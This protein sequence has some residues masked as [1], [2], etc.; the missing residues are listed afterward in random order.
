MVLTRKISKEGDYL[1]MK[2]DG[3]TVASLN[4]KNGKSWGA[5]DN[6]MMLHRQAK[7]IRKSKIRVV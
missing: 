2:E 3:Y 7:E 4:L 5:T 6:I 1:R